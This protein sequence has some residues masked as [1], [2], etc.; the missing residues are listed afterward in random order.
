MLVLVSLQ[1][2]TPLPM[3]DEKAVQTVSLNSAASLTFT[4]DSQP[5]NLRRQATHNSNIG[6]T[7][8][9]SAETANIDALSDHP[10]VFDAESSD[11]WM[12]GDLD[13]FANLGGLDAG[14]SSILAG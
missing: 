9:I 1:D 11:F 3:I 4:D 8:T 12:Q 10:H 5:E 13:I 6:T 14:L 2:F 7:Y